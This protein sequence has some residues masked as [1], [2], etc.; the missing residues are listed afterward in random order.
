MALDLPQW[1]DMDEDERVW[2][3][4][5]REARRAGF[6]HLEAET[7]AWSDIDIGHL[8]KLVDGGCDG[9]TAADILL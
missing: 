8:R 3:N 7:F 9:K 4:R 5:Y 6:E 2:A 1:E